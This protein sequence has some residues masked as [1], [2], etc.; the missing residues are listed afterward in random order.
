MTTLWG[1]GRGNNLGKLGKLPDG[2]RGHGRPGRLSLR[3]EASESLHGEIGNDRLTMGRGLQIW[4]RESRS[5]LMPKVV[6][7]LDVPEDLDYSSSNS[8]GVGTGATVPT[9]PPP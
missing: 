8:A 5:D 6:K 7:F 2:R 4:L 9:P 3:G 1:D